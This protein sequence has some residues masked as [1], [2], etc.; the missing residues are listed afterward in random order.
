MFAVAGLSFG[1]GTRA[2]EEPSGS[3]VGLVDAS[4]FK[5]IPA[6]AAVAL[7]D[8]AAKKWK[9]EAVLTSIS[10]RGVLQEWSRPE[11][12]RT[13]D[14]ADVKTGE[15]TRWLLEYFSPK[16]RELLVVDIL[17]GKV[18]GEPAAMGKFDATSKPGVLGKKWIDSPVALEIARAEIESHLKISQADYMAL[19]RLKYFDEDHPTWAIS[20]TQSK[21]DK[22]LYLVAVNA[23]TRQV[24]QSDA[25]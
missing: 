10:Q 8:A 17:D 16:T 11:F 12:G 13:W 20:F 1:C 24:E 15:S 3:A 21:G 19:S 9:K 22:P 5:K 23:V 7:G 2:K 18:D 14:F 25:K 4:H 6:S